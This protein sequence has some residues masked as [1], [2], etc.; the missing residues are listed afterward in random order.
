M[1]SYYKHVLNVITPLK[2][3]KQFAEEK[4]ERLRRGGGI[5]KR[6]ALILKRNTPT[7]S[8]PL[9]S[10]KLRVEKSICWFRH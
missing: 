4:L 1:N 8:R 9:R 6:P 5:I 7:L 10:K 3:K 2:K